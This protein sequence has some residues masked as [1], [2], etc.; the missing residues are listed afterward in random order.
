MLVIYLFQNKN[1]TL[2]ELSIQDSSIC[3]VLIYRS[4]PNYNF[5]STTVHQ[6]TAIHNRKAFNQ[7]SKADSLSNQ[8]YILTLSKPTAN[9]AIR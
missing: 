9:K 8:R 4:K 3:C 2:D 6:I 5:Q 7:Q 1:A